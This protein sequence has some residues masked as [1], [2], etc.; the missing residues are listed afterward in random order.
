MGVGR[1]MG[2]SGL[3]ESVKPLEKNVP[4]LRNF[5]RGLVMGLDMGLYTRKALTRYVVGMTGEAK[6]ES[7]FNPLYLWTLD[8]ALLFVE[9]G[10]NPICLFDGRRTPG[11]RFA[12]E[13]RRKAREK[14]QAKVRV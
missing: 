10:A 4:D 5:L 12:H 9:R 7:K 3:R 2:V 8:F 6:V 13:K 11:K 1:G 14:A